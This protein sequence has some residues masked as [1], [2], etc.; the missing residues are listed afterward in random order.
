MESGAS[1]SHTI[2][3][4]SSESHHHHHHVTS[5]KNQSAQS[6]L[7][8]ESVSPSN[9]TEMIQHATMVMY[10]DHHQ[11]VQQ[12]LSEDPIGTAGH[13]SVRSVDPISTLNMQSDHG[14]QVLA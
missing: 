8:Q 14:Q 11:E 7:A 10:E 4:H 2:P 3:S 13:E 12:V 1:G 5:S 6:G 9:E